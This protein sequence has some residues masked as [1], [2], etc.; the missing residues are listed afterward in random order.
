MMSLYA[1]LLEVEYKGIHFYVSRRL[2]IPLE[3][4]NGKTLCIFA[5]KSE[6]LLFVHRLYIKDSC[7]VLRSEKAN[8]MWKWLKAVISQLG[9]LWMQNEE[10]LGNPWENS[11]QAA[12]T[13]D[14]SKQSWLVWAQL[15]VLLDTVWSPASGLSAGLLMRHLHLLYTVYVF[16]V[17]LNQLLLKLRIS[18]YKK[19]H[20]KTSL[21]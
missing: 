5:Q 11:P 7:R 21:R 17:F 10:K 13:Y 20:M 19:L 2:L 18:L 3:L 6:F 4:N 9:F 15:W 8:P 12:L 1:I 16:W 14:L